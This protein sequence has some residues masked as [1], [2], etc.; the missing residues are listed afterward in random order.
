MKKFFFPIF[1]ILFCSFANAESRLNFGLDVDIGFVTADFGSYKDK[2]LLSTS[3]GFSAEYLHINESHLICGVNG[4]LSFRD[5]VFYTKI[6]TKDQENML[7][8]LSFQF[9]PIIG[10]AFG[11]KNNFQLLLSP[12]VFDFVEFNEASSGDFT[13]DINK[14]YV[15]YKTS[16]K[17]NLLFG[18]NFVR[19]GFYTGF[20]IIWNSKDYLS[21]A[22]GCEFCFGYKLDLAFI[23]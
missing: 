6:G 3:F 15:A 21:N 23:D 17:M 8:G 18:K 2:H 9:S 5:E 20:T 1:L 4:E 7:S 16:L 11:S 13:I 10:Y 19:N 22:S 14:S 12:I